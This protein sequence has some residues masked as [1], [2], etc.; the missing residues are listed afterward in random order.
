MKWNDA[1]RS[2]MKWTEVTKR[3]KMSEWMNELMNKDE[4][5]KDG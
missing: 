5:M 1:K 3:L 4:W 2:E